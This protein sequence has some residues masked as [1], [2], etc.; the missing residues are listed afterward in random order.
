MAETTPVDFDPFA[1]PKAVE[2]DPFA[3]PK[4]PSASSSAAPPAEPEKP[5][6]SAS[7]MLKNFWNPEKFEEAGRKAQGEA[8]TGVLSG[9]A[10]T[11]MGIPQFAAKAIPGETGDA[12]EQYLAE[13][14]QALKEQCDE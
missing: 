4:A 3:A 5:G 11:L 9:S 14:Q 1:A 2:F 8:A 6:F 13:R 12:V 10:Q 7:R